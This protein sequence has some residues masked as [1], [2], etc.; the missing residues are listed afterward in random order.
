MAVSD[1]SNE[2][3]VEGDVKKCYTRKVPSSQFNLASHAGG[4]KIKHYI[5][6]EQIGEGSYGVVKEVFDTLAGKRYAMKIITDRKLRNIPG[7]EE[8]IT[9]ETEI[10]RQIQYKHC[11]EFV[12]FWRDEEHEK[13]YLV[14]EYVGGGSVRELMDRAPKKR[15]PVKQARRIFRQLLKALN[16]L[17]TNGLVHRDVKPENIMITTEGMVKLSD[18][19]VT[20][21][22]EDGEG[23][24]QEFSVRNSLGKSTSSSGSIDSANQQ[25]PRTQHR[26]G[27]PAFQPPEVTSGQTPFS[28]PAMDIWAA[29]VVLYEM[30]LGKYPFHGVGNNVKQLLENISQCKCFFPP[31]MEASLS[32]ML[33]GLL[34]PDPIKRFNMAQIREHPWMQKRLKLEEEF[35]PLSR[36]PTAFPSPTAK[37]SCTIS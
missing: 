30:I 37:P 10:M 21:S 5:I 29:G 34:E 3:A 20:C 14:L 18:F 35:V 12:E 32:S 31:E 6:G 25:I 26:H 15:I 2:S 36:P 17:H 4:K 1:R 19:G 8:G 22:I 24:N 11:I 23:E 7:G 9:S 13:A 27:S 28:G 33:H 16:Y